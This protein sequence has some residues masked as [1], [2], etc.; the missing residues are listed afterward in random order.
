MSDV[1]ATAL[2]ARGRFL[3]DHDIVTEAATTSTLAAAQI[4]ALRSNVTRAV[5]AVFDEQ[6][7]IAIIALL[8]VRST[9]QACRV[10]RQHGEAISEQ[11][12]PVVPERQ[13]VTARGSDG[14]LIG[15]FVFDDPHQ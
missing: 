8:D 10:W 11:P 9:E 14:A 13:I 4:N 2:V 1:D 5:E 7:L 15:R 6:Q 12:E 3:R